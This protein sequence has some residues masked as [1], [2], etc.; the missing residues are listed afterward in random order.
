MA[1]QR[2]MSC[3]GWKD[4]YVASAHTDL[5]ALSIFNLSQEQR[6]IA[7][8]DAFSIKVSLLH[9]VLLATNAPTV[10]FMRIW[11]KVPH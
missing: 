1:L 7:L 6:R 10:A 11:V 2:G 5:N 8:E 3:S 9:Y 4:N